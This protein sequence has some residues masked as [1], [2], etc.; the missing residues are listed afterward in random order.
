MVNEIIVAFLGSLPLVKRPQSRPIAPLC[1]CTASITAHVPEVFP[2]ARPTLT[3]LA[4]DT[5]HRHHV[6]AGPSALHLP[7]VPLDPPGGST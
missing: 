5:A 1:S 4:D 6:T 7:V 2:S 3:R